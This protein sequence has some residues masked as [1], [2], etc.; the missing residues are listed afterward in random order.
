MHFL[1][2]SGYIFP[3]DC[4]II[5]AMT[6][7]SKCF[8]F[9]LYIQEVTYIRNLKFVLAFKFKKQT[10]FFAKTAKKKYI[11]TSFLIKDIV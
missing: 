6:L 4:V 8:L 1:K 10:A 2:I 5:K 11:A 9:E 7:S 3:Y